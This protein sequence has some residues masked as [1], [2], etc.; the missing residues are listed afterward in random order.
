M[1]TETTLLVQALDELAEAPAPPSRIDIERARTSGRRRLHLRRAGVLGGLAALVL[2][3]SLTVTALPGPE[4]GSGKRATETD[5]A[6]A[7]EVGTDPL[8]AHASFGWLPPTIVGVGYQVGAH[9]D[10]AM[11]RGTGQNPTTILLKVYPAGTTPGLGTFA[12]GATQVRVPTEPINGR[13]AYWV[14]AD[15]ADPTNAGDT[16]L[17]WQTADGRWAEIHAYYLISSDLQGVLR[18][19]A[20]TVTAGEAAVPLPIRVKG[21][22]AGFRLDEAILDRPAPGSGAWTLQLIYSVDGGFVDINVAPAGAEGRPAD[23]ACATAHGLQ[24]CVEAPQGVP[25]SLA[26]IGGTKGLLD[27]ITPLG[28]DEHNWT[29]NVIVG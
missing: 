23:G 4:S 10:L 25:P 14:S 21:L 2:A 24:V 8:T 28:M 15:S 20:S 19:V 1:T 18:H 12:T 9:D 29:T 13:S 16:Y 11:A 26:A 27:R 3:A 5:A 6:A 17:R 22:P 7:G